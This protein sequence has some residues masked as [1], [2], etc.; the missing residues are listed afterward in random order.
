MSKLSNEFKLSK[1]NLFYA[2]QVENLKLLLKNLL[3]L[4]TNE[5]ET[6]LSAILSYLQ[7]SEKMGLLLPFNIKDKIFPTSVL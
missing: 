7:K 6:W 3:R 1:I 2:L 5:S 4:R